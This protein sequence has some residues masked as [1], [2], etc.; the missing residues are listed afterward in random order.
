MRDK[1]KDLH[2]QVEKSEHLPEVCWSSKRDTRGVPAT[3]RM[4]QL[5]NLTYRRF[6]QLCEA[7]A[8]KGENIHLDDD[9]IFACDLYLDLSQ[10]VTRRAYAPHIRG[11]CANA[12]YFSFQ[13]GRVLSPA[14][15]L[16][17]L[18]WSRSVK[19]GTLSSTMLR[20][21]AGESMAQPCLSLMLHSIMFTWRGMCGTSQ[22][23]R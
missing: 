5:V 13:H 14:E 20:E 6:H 18:G 9:G 11:M 1:W 19:L 3:P 2:A 22:H 8:A 17:L 4:Q 7:R 12:C 10:C 15:H 23:R 21:L 16:Y